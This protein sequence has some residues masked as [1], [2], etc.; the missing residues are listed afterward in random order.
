MPLDWHTLQKDVSSLFA[1][2]QVLETELNQQVPGIRPFLGQLLPFNRDSWL[3]QSECGLRQLNVSDVKKYPLKEEECCTIF[4]LLELHSH[5]L[6]CTSFLL[7]VLDLICTFSFI[8]CVCWDM[9]KA[10]L[11]LWLEQSWACWLGTNAGKGIWAV[12]SSEY[13]GRHRFFF[14]EMHAACLKH[15]WRSLSLNSVLV[16][17]GKY[18]DLIPA[19]VRNH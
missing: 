5:G 1:S 4:W 11:C 3:V 19:S 10:L 17:L 7:S 16:V 6:G 9:W 8:L 14:R 12:K 13:C 15:F 18:E 2:V